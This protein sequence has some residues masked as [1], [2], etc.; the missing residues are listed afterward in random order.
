MVVIP[1]NAVV[2]RIKDVFKLKN[3]PTTVPINAKHVTIAAP[4][5]KFDNIIEMS[6]S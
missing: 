2:G 5:N 4:F 6:V 1:Q 3:T